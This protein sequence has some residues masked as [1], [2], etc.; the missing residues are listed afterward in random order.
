MP[1]DSMKETYSGSLYALACLKFKKLKTGKICK[2]ISKPAAAQEWVVSPG[3]ILRRLKLGNEV[4][5]NLLTSSGHG[6]R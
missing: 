5:V 6:H 2:C 1:S 3:I 4:A